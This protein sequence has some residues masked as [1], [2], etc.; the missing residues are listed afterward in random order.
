MLFFYLLLMLHTYHCLYDDNLP[1]NRVT[2][3]TVKGEMAVTIAHLSRISW[4]LL[5]PECHGIMVD[6][7]V[8]ETFKYCDM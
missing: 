4:T 2:I 6:S 3:T 5:R 8:T 7:L 1:T